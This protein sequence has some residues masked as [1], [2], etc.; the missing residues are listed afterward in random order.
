MLFT[1]TVTITAAEIIAGGAVNFN[2]G[3]VGFYP[4]A[5]GASANLVFNSTPFGSNRD[6]LIVDSAGNVPV[7]LSNTLLTKTSDGFCG[8]LAATVVNDTG[9]A[10]SGSGLWFE[11]SG[12][13]TS[14][15]SDVQVTVMYVLVPCV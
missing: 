6:L 12:G 1:K 10:T 7:R 5:I 13:S 3:V 15:D 11:F 2:I 9:G 4:L 14:G 8:G